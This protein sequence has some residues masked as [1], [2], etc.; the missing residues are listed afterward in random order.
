M[1]A[2]SP[3]SVRS[4]PIA[5]QEAGEEVVYSYQLIAD[6]MAGRRSSGLD[7]RSYEPLIRRDMR[8]ALCGRLL[9]SEISREASVNFWL[10][11]IVQ[12]V[13]KD[14][15]AGTTVDDDCFARAVA[16]RNMLVDTNAGIVHSL[17]NK[18]VG[19]DDRLRAELL[20]AMNMEL[21]YA[22]SAFVPR[23]GGPAFSNYLYG[24]CRSKAHQVLDEMRY[25]SVLNASQRGCVRAFLSARNHLRNM[26]GVEP[27][28]ND[29]IETLGHR[30]ITEELSNEGAMMAAIAIFSMVYLDAPVAG[31][32][33][34][35]KVPIVLGE[36]ISDSSDPYREA[37]LSDMLSSEALGS[38]GVSQLD[39]EIFTLHRIE[40][41]TTRDISE[42]LK[43]GEIG[44][45][46]LSQ[47]VSRMSVTNAV[48]RVEAA[49]S[50]LFK[51]ET[52][53]GL[54]YRVLGREVRRASE[55]GDG[56]LTDTVAA[57]LL[58][59]AGVRSLTT[60]EVHLKVLDAGVYATLEQVD[61]TLRAIHSRSVDV[62][63]TE[64][65]T[66]VSERGCEWH[67]GVG[68]LPVSAASARQSAL[69][70]TAA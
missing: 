32:S 63:L 35:Q 45:P 37:D 22:A 47:G 2:H 59:F 43:S 9:D 5:E 27:G 52:S 65:C 53:L 57:T 70:L 24:R 13:V 14:L 56:S 16:A 36:A 40:G 46:E 38:L 28:F 62:P 51:A 58:S 23:E 18:H 15:K 6:E 67:M 50:R 11:G 4:E 29:V 44:G 10:A 7:Y 26:L 64:V 61:R 17:A 48:K 1:G 69:A 49:L 12:G 20:S 55:Q 30:D 68:R 54:R 25:P 33:D 21:L 3:E 66:V 41:L 42:G 39:L 60:E 8:R 34:D 31:Y 19:K